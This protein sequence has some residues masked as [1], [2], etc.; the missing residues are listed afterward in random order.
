MIRSMSAKLSITPDRD[1]GRD[2]RYLPSGAYFLWSSSD[3]WSGMVWIIREPTALYQ[4]QPYVTFPAQ[5]ERL[6]MVAMQSS[7]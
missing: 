2:C 1:G 4:W 7:A 6:L 3:S 5:H